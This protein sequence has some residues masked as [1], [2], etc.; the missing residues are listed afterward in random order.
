MA[1]CPSCNKFASLD[2]Q[3]IDEPDLEVTHEYDEASKVHTYAVTG[4]LRIVRSSSCCGDEMKEYNFEVSGEVDF[5]HDELPED[6]DWDDCEVSVTSMDQ[7]EEG[8]GRYAKSY[9]GATLSFTVTV[10]IGNPEKSEKSGEWTD[11]VAASF[12]DELT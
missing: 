10:G 2:F 11:K 8:G 9:F 7:V 12:M 6:T 3:D 1:N 4:E 5:N